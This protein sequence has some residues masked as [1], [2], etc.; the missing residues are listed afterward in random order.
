MEVDVERIFVRLASWFP[1]RHPVLLL[2]LL[3]LLK[4]LRQLVESLLMLVPNVV[5]EMSVAHL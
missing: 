5:M 1:V 4:L 2:L 3:L